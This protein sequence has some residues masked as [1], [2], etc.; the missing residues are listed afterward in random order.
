MLHVRVNGIVFEASCVETRMPRLPNRARLFAAA[1]LL[2]VAGCGR[3]PL[4]AGSSGPTG[5]AGS[6]GAGGPGCG[7]FGHATEDVVATDVL[8]LLDASGSM[9]DDLQ[10]T[11]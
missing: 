8:I 9:N 6:E 3:R 10:N 7:T 4:L 1:L 2:L 5:G 11:V